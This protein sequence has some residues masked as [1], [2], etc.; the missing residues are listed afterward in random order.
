MQ[1]K[2]RS[3]LEEL[4]SANLTQDKEN[5]V[6]SRAS[7]ILDSSINLFGFIRENFD[8]ETAYKLEKKFLTAVK[9]MDPSKFNNGVSRI[10][11]LKRIKETLI[12]KK[13]E[14]NED[15]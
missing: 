8:Q 11:E 7:H 5:L 15:E 13:G 12:I 4:T 14:Y 1:K 3:I 9:Q 10:K 6:L 2:T